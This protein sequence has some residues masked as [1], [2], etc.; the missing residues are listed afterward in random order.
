MLSV[1]VDRMPQEGIKGQ[2]DT[3]NQLDRKW[4][5]HISYLTIIQFVG[6][7]TAKEFEW[8]MLKK[9]NA[10]IRNEKQD[11]RKQKQVLV[12]NVTYSQRANFV[13]EVVPKCMKGQRN[14]LQRFS[15]EMPSM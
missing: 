14:V 2:W 5:Q 6:T 7:I 8:K 1:S 12:Q 4:T 9:H 3:I 10:L 13:S 11:V 15:Q